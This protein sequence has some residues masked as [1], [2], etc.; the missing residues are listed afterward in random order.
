MDE[1]RERVR[2]TYGDAK[3]E[4]LVTLKNRFDPENIFHR[5]QNIAPSEPGQTEMA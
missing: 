4:R 2:H 3:H 5:N 1:G